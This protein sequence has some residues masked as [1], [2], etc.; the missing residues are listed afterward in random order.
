[1]SEQSTIR[2]KPKI[3]TIT[4]K[5]SSVAPSQQGLNGVPSDRQHQEV[6]EDEA[7]EGDTTPNQEDCFSYYA[8]RTWD[9]QQGPAKLRYKTRRQ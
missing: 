5:G 6:E 3:K 4:I 9:I 7:E 8:G 1:M 2:L